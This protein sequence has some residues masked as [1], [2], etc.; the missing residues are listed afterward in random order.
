MHAESNLQ[1]GIV[2]TF[3]ELQLNMVNAVLGSHMDAYP[4]RKLS[5]RMMS[6]TI[7]VVL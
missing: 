3:L 1:E 6:L 2:E 4:I 5:Q 7:S